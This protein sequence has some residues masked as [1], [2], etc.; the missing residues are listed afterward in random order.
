MVAIHGGPPPEGLAGNYG[1]CGR[2]SGDAEG[3][4]PGGSGGR[5]AAEVIWR[6]RGSRG[7]LKGAWQPRQSRG[8]R[9]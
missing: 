3:G 8:R 4:D 5:V 6:A 9:G 1:R 2:V 7:N